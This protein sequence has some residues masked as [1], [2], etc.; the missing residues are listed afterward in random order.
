MLDAGAAVDNLELTAL[1]DGS[2]FTRPDVF[3]GLWRNAA[4]VIYRYN[5]ASIADGVETLAQKL[6]VGYP[7]YFYVLPFF[8]RNN[9]GGQA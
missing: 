4:F 9:E 5:H 2:I 3:G 1:D 6:N 7:G 8:T